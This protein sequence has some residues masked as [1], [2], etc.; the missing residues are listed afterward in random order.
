MPTTALSA[1]S[2]TE[3]LVVAGPPHALCG[4]LR[5]RNDSEEKLKV[6]GFALRERAGKKGAPKLSAAT[7]QAAARLRPGEEAV[8]AM[9]LAVSGQ[10]TPGVYVMEV[11]IGD[12]TLPV[13]AHVTEHVDLKLEPSALT[14]LVGSNLEIEREFV[15]E[16][17]GNVA[18]PLG[19]RCE[20]PL[21]GSTD[22]VTALRES[23]RNNVGEELKSRI[24]KMLDE[25]GRVQI[26]SLVIE[27]ERV[28]LSPG[29]RRQLKVRFVLPEDIKPSRHY[30]AVLG[31][32]NATLTVDIYTTEKAGK[33]QRSAK[34]G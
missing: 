29:E 2:E 1:S 23:L 4:R 19:E 27:R 9:H 15:F 18:L 25:I 13:E 28:T 3:T 11:E 5:L 6:R 26:G 32:Y 7:M 20:A 34:N 12:R 10:T 8:V 30:W 17:V 16:N 24:E 21:L 14:L 22:L 31:L 33:Q